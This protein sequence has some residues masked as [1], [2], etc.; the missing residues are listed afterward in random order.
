MPRGVSR[1][2]VLESLTEAHSAGRLTSFDDHQPLAD[3]AA[4]KACLN[5]LHKTNRA[6]QANG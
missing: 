6:P 2:V 3:K 4:F 1:D 5:P